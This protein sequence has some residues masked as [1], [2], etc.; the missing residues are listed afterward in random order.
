MLL[1]IIIVAI[2]II[3]IATMLLIFLSFALVNI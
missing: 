2:I 3:F 1:P